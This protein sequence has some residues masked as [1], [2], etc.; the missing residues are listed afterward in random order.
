MRA[1]ILEHGAT[2]A[3]LA[4]TRA[5]ACAGWT[6]GI[7]C[8]A[9]SGLAAS[10]RFASHRHRVPPP[11]RDQEPFVAGL[12][13]AVR[14][15]RYD[16]VFGAGDAEI[17]AL[18][19]NRARIDANVP[20][21]PHEQVVNALDKL[22]LARATEA[23]GL[24]APATCSA[25]AEAL[26]GAQFPVMV[27]AALHV[28]LQ[29][30]GGAHRLEA[31]LAS[32]LDTAAGRATEIRRAGGDPLLQELVR[33]KLVA[34]AVLADRESRIVAWEAQESD[35]LWPPSAGVSA[36]AKTVAPDPRMRAPIESLIRRLQWFGIAQLQFLVPTDGEPR[37]IDL[38][39]RF[40]GSLALAVAAGTNLPALWAAL[41]VGEEVRPVEAVPG[42]RYQWMEGDLRRAMAERRSGAVRDLVDVLRYAR[43]ASHSVWRRDDLT[44]A[45]RYLRLMGIR[46]LR[47][48]TPGRSRR[49]TPTSLDAHS[50]RR[51]ARA[52]ST[53]EAVVL[54]PDES[55]AEDA[56]REL[57]VTRGNAFVSPEWHAAWLRHYGDA[58]RPLLIAAHDSDGELVGLM[59]M[60]VER[61]G[62][63]RVA[64]FAGGPLGDRFHPCA[65]PR[66]EV[67][68]AAAAGR[69]LSRLDRSPGVLVLDHVS[70]DARWQQELAANS[71]FRIATAGYRQ[72][73][74]P[75]I[76]LSEAS[77]ETYLAGRSRNFRSQVRRKERALVRTHD[78]RFRAT[79]DSAQLHA[80]MSLFFRLHDA[81]W[82]ER[83]GSRLA[84]PRARAFHMDFAGAALRRDWLRLWFLELDGEAV[85]AWY[86]WQ[87]GGRYSYYLAGFDPRWADAS[88]G[89]V[90]LAH[91]IRS[92]IEEGCSVYELLLGEE[93][94]KWRFATGQEHVATVMLSGPGHAGRLAIAAEVGAWRIG[95]SLP[96]R[97][98]GVAQRGYRRFAGIF[99]AARR[100]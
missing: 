39:G 63:L 14:D 44:P 7:G 26:R 28:P 23:A 99:P 59:P 87:I 12:G 11:G 34:Y 88:V 17:L 61:T 95:N 64:R 77:W 69:A 29:N 80:D 62:P 38:N 56:W 33:G 79:H 94:Y 74:L 97:F 4:A 52:E 91:T 40:Y 55:G 45:A 75:E 81:R 73:S 35:R 21:P 24:R 46:A 76:D 25:T 68:V 92:A 58:T 32:D 89:F 36:R 6:V 54:S 67:A 66:D 47:R 22:S 31:S 20:Y 9:G 50:G 42:L 85:A 100:R 98:R 72:T 83:G 48:L 96:L 15:G 51:L 10:S 93:D 19:L 18:S 60:V 70:V 57:A 13:A 86:G 84:S 82:A 90:L 1:L 8:P 2:R 27:K 5:L 37:L 65:R 16:V 71:G 30:A 53:L 49:D 3:A 41:A 78:L 43:G